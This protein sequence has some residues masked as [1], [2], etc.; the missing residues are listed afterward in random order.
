MVLDRAAREA[1]HGLAHQLRSIEGIQRSIEGEI[2]LPL[3]RRPESN[4]V[5][6]KWPEVEVVCTSEPL[7]LD[8]YVSSIGDPKLVIDM[9]VGDLQR[10]IE[11]TKLGYAIEQAVPG[12]VH[13]AY[14]ALLGS[15]FDSRLLTP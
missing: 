2:G 12:E 7:E 10:V 13:D 9:L 1:A 4:R 6:V 5:S 15:G 14:Q 3:P 8:D 11:Y